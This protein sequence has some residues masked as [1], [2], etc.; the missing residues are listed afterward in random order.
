M[1]ADLE[2]LRTFRAEDGSVDDAS[3]HAAR[4]ALMR[5]IAADGRPDLAAGPARRPRPER[6]LTARIRVDLIAAALS[7]VVVVGVG[8]VVLSAGGE[9]QRPSPV[10]LPGGHGPRVLHNLAPARPPSLP[11][12]VLC[13]ADLA[14]PGAIAGV[15][16]S[17]SGIVVVTGA[18]VHGINEAPFSIS[19]TGLAPL[20]GAEIYAVWLLPAV[21]QTAGGYTVL[22]PPHP[23]LLGV[24][25]PGVGPGGRLAVAGVL[26]ADVSGAYLVQITRQS[27]SATR[28]P[29]RP[30]LEGFAVL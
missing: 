21:D 10:R 26:P 18:V 1:S 12:Q 4:A 29:G 15:G 25:A 2:L 3:V 16:G 19:A 13:D 28:T 14:R 30:V 24:V 6:G 9:H 8:A 27:R 22:K 23:R 5:H 17:P 20:A 7:L 11:G